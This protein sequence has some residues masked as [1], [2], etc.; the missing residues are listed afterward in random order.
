MYNQSS[1]RVSSREYFEAPIRYLKEERGPFHKSAGK[2][3]S[4]LF[5]SFVR[6]LDVAGSLM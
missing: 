5:G 6:F 1:V 4:R 2:G 3:S